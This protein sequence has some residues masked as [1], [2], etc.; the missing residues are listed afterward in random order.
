VVRI[1]KH[2]VDFFASLRRLMWW[3]RKNST[4]PPPD[5]AGV[6]RPGIVKVRK[7]HGKWRRKRYKRS[8]IWH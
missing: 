3:P 2:A 8:L 5:K 1:N 4:V 7:A 6:A